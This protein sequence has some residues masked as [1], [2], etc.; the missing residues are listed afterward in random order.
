M[1]LFHREAKVAISIGGC[2]RVSTLQKIRLD[3]RARLQVQ[4]PKSV[5][6]TYAHKFANSEIYKVEKK[7][8]F[9]F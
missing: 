2:S 3:K 4:V 8:H 9:G 6:G 7:F 5:H 1:L